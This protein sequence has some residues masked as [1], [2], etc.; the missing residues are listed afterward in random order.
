MS[1]A[2]SFRS[3]D[4]STAEQWAEIGARTAERQARV[5]PRVLGM[6]EALG[7]VVDGFAV[8][9]LRHSLQTATRAERAGADEEMVVAAL[10]H[11][12][13]KYV[14]VPNHPRIAAEI[15]RP[16]VRD[17]VFDVIRTHQDFQGRHY[18]HH[19]GATPT[20]GSSTGARRGSPWVS[21]SPTSGTRPAS[22]R[23]TPP[24]PSSTSSRSSAPSS[25]A[26]AAS[27][28]PHLRHAAQAR[29]RTGR[30]AHRP[31]PPSPLTRSPRADR[32]GTCEGGWPRRAVGP[33]R[34]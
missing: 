1:T 14:S 15:L 31:T 10:C 8:D 22:T 17:E 27:D 11:D 30:P 21:G 4:E 3:M 25:P 7:D 32:W 29:P 18:Y 5:A 19:F 34:A 6:L 9:Q 26:P 16:Y 20:P 24:R 2:T 23:T 13:G 28:A 33:G 12:V